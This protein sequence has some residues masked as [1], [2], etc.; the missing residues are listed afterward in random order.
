M[1][2]LFA[3]AL[4]LAMMLSVCVCAQAAE[5]TLPLTETPV[6]LNIA[7]GRHSSDT[8]EDF[9][10]KYVFQEAAK[11]TGVTINWQP[12]NEG[13]S[14]K[15]AVLLSSDMPEIFLGLLSDTQIAQNSS[16]FV[17]LN[18]KLEADCPN[19]YA[20][21]NDN[22]EG[23]QDY[24]TY[25]DG[26]IYGLMGNYY[27]SANNSLQG[28]MWINKV[29]LDNLGLAV[30][31]N[32][33]ELQ[34]ALTAFKDNDADG[35]GDATNEIPMDFCQKHYAASYWELAYSFGLTR[36]YD[37]V[38][39]KV[40]PTANTDTFRTFLEYYHDLCANGLANVEGLTQ[41]DEQYNANLSNMK[42]GAFWGWA[43]YTY[44]SDPEAQAQYV[45]VGPL[46]ADGYTF[47]VMPS[48][49]TAQRNCF[50]VTTA[51]KNVDVALKWWDYLSRDQVAANT[52]RSGPQGLT[53]DLDETGDACSKKYTADDAKA[54]GYDE[55]SSQA[56][57]STFA[58]SMGLTNCPPL[59]LKA[60]T[61]QQGTTSA[62]RNDAIK[63]YEQYVTEQSMAKGIIPNEAQEEFD[64]TC[65]GLT[66]FIDSYACD[67]ILNGVTDAS[68]DA[69]IDG[70]N[71]HSYDYYIEFYQKYLDNAF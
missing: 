12:I 33:N 60:L 46:S 31:T 50:V 23:W 10:D 32:L 13:D 7:V 51:C 69:Y 58:A 57:T 24:L 6:T 8:V 53:W 21:Y 40:T 66:E 45:C 34:D 37:I 42:V 52:A 35:D 16:L 64:F 30:P 25:P 36:Y 15:I 20:L 22:V 54:F 70:L 62:I 19:V 18:D 61:P 3:L 44:M 49:M 56:G 55:L 29:W 65:E 14:E 48:R 9:N 28:T 5:V 43:P 27:Y 2:K 71:S 47:R 38:D 67:A 41:T 11:V 63:L 26:N 59:I 68:W 17:P 4:A 1:K 39:G